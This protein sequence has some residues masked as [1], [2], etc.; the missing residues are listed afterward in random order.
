MLA[1]W[2]P[3][4]LSSLSTSM[5]SW[6]LGSMRSSV[7]ASR[8]W[9]MRTSVLTSVTPLELASDQTATLAS[10]AA[11]SHACVLLLAVLTSELVPVLAS[12]RPSMLGGH[13]PRYCGGLRG[14]GQPWL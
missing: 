8:Q 1:P 3:W 12:I 7:L 10:E 4:T 6:R 11:E 5:R 13:N 9:S 14:C 2:L